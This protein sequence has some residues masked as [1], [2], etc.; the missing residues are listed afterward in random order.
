M[1]SEAN[2]TTVVFIGV[3]W[4]GIIGIC[5]DIHII[6]WVQVLDIRE[7]SPGVYHLFSEKNLKAWDPY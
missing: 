1:S 5:I 4:H 2:R 6:H 3:L 7:R